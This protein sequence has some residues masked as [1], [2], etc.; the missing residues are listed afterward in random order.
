M[1]LFSEVYERFYD[2]CTEHDLAELEEET[3]N[4]ILE[5]YL[6]YAISRF[7][8]CKTNLSNL[9]EDKNG[10]AETLNTREIDIL[11]NFMVLASIK[12]KLHNSDLYRNGLSTK[13]YSMFS[14]ANMLNS[15]QNVYNETKRDIDDLIIK[16]SNSVNDVS[17]WGKK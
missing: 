2:L 8:I 11:A 5:G 10:F 16:Y 6:L 13:E 4:D 17:K 3:V 14:P 9:N 7:D 1:T 12:P 15:I